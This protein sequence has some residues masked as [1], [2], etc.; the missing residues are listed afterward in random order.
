M[1]IHVGYLDISWE[2]CTV[3]KISEHFLKIFKDFWKLSEHCLKFIRTFLII[4]RKFQMSENYQRLLNISE[5][6]LKTFWTHSNRFWFV[7]QLNLV[8][9]IA[10][11]TSYVKISNLSSHVKKS[12]F[13]GKRKPCSSLTEVYI[14]VI[15][16]C[17]LPLIKRLITLYLWHNK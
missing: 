10:H 16:C 13:H 5:Q 1:L 3:I 12:C 17:I 6:S 8:N 9:L 4:L 14:H 7:Q 11:M 2:C 15:I